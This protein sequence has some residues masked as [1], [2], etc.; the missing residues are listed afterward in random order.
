M[1]TIRFAAIG[2]SHNHI[3]GQVNVLLKADAQLVAFWGEEPDR[4]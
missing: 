1:M 4:V 3:Y 2:L